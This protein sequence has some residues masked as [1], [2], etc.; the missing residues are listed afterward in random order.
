M[1]KLS[2]WQIHVYHYWLSLLENATIEMLCFCRSGVLDFYLN[3][4]TLSTA[5]CQKAGSVYLK[6][7]TYA[8]ASSNSRNEITQACFKLLLSWW[9]WG[10]PQTGKYCNQTRHRFLRIKMLLALFLL[11]KSKC[12]LSFLSFTL[13]FQILSIITQ[14]SV[15]SILYLQCSIFL[16]STDFSSKQE[17]DD[18]K[19]D[20]IKIIY[21]YIYI[22]NWFFFQMGKWW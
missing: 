19:N 13:L 2:W 4:L 11:M 14:Y 5:L 20:V 3:E 22:I 18:S 17:N 9:T 16:L 15:W 7:L 21:I 6:L 8:G 1:R 12:K 10:V